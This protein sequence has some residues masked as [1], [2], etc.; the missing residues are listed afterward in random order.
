MRCFRKKPLISSPPGDFVM[1]K[2][3]RI[4]K[5]S[6]GHMLIMSCLFGLANCYGGGGGGGE[7]SH[8][9]C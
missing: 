5:T 7:W 4:L 1:S 9:L 6:D 3:V 2:F 8:S